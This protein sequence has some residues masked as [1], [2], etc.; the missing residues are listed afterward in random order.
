LP[1]VDSPSGLA[2]DSAGNL[3]IANVLSSTISKVDSSETF[4]TFAHP[5]KPQ[6][7][8]T[9][10]T[11]LFV[12]H[13]DESN[14]ISKV[15]PAGTVTT[16]LTLPNFY[17][18]G[19]LAYDPANSL[20]WAGDDFGNMIKIAGATPTYYPL[21]S[22]D[23]PDGVTIDSNH[24]AAFVSD[25]T[26][27]Q[28]DL[29]YRYGSVSPTGNITEFTT[30]F[31][32]GGM[33]TDPA[34]NLYTT[35]IDGTLHF[36]KISPTNVITTFD[37]GVVA[38]AN[39]VLYSTVS[40]PEPSSLFATTALWAGLLSRRRIRQ[41][42]RSQTKGLPPIR[43]RN[44]LPGKPSTSASAALHLP[45]PYVPTHGSG[46]VPLAINCSDR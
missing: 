29:V 12:N 34:G 21:S 8:A 1:L 37:T 20:L 31:A 43:R 32:P 11:N 17:E 30:N 35:Y 38:S 28:H 13:Q 7:L 19:G 14:T 10:G 15:G 3:Y 16:L 26:N 23:S 9:D 36:A 18:A 42:S 27:L 24:N 22:T 6:D 45:V 40:I 46:T 41:C 2:F 44:A 39:A 33:T 4:T 25:Y 5:H